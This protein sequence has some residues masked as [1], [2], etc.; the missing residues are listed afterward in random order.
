MK[1][2]N[3]EPNKAWLVNKTDQGS[4]PHSL[5]AINADEEGRG[6]STRGRIFQPVKTDIFNY[7]RNTVIFCVFIFHLLVNQ[8]STLPY[9]ELMRSP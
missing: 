9:D 7:E 4:L 1:S 8:K 2:H 6:R 3:L 5:H